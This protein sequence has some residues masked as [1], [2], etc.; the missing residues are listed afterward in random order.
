MQFWEEIRLWSS[1]T[2]VVEV[3]FQHREPF[4]DIIFYEI[5]FLIFLSYL[6]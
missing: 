1:D 4:L 6:L 3:Q 2:I 5:I